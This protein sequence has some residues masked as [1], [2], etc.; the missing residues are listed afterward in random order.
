M[1]TNLEKTCIGLQGRRIRCLI[2]YQKLD[3]GLFDRIESRYIE[4]LKSS[5]RERRNAADQRRS[6]SSLSTSEQAKAAEE[7]DRYE[8]A[9]TQINEF[10]EMALELSATH[11]R[12]DDD[13]VQVNCSG[14]P[15]QKSPNFEEERRQD[16]KL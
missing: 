4:P 9:L 12:E 7:F 13:S 1:E 2:D 16:L 11:T 6:D 15:S 8:R 3:A 5:Y 10:Q 14:P